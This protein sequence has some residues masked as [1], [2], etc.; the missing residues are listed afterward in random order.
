MIVCRAH[1]TSCPL[2][3]HF[4]EAEFQYSIKASNTRG[5]RSDIPLEFHLRLEIR[6][7]IHR[8]VMNP[9]IAR[10]PRCRYPTNTRQV[11]F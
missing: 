10:F 11:S 1:V 8:R 3:L 6:G 5:R 7:Q 2:Y 9:K 4:D